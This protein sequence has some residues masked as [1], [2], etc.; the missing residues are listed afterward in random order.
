MIGILAFA[1][2][3]SIAYYAAPS[4]PLYS[5]RDIQ[6]IS[7]HF[8]LRQ[9]TISA[10]ILA[11]VEIDNEN[12]VGG[13]LYSAHVDIYYPDWNGELQNIGYLQETKTDIEVCSMDRYGGDKDDDTTSL[14]KEEDRGVCIS[15]ETKPSPFFS[16]QSRGVSTS[17]PG[18]V[19]I[20]LQNVPPKTY[21]NVMRHVFTQWGSIVL[22]VSG[23]THVKSPLGVHLSLGIICDNELDLTK[24][25]IQIVGRSCIV[26]RISTGWSGLTDL[27]A[28]VKD[29]VQEYYSEFDGDIFRRR[30]PPE[31][32]D[33][34]G[35]SR[36]KPK[37]LSGKSMDVFFAS[38]EVVL[39]WHDF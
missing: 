16:V 6:L 29:Q 35:G 37:T 11:G 7:F 24:H 14:Q 27:A 34:K 15:E 5:A 33:G 21:L 23:A 2:L 30:A 25:P 39:D 31:N 26:E 13:D 19:T 28:E 20:Y 3:T 10:K 38:S 22:L 12:V 32:N 18:A 9:L 17:K 1:L 4:M 36:R 8:S